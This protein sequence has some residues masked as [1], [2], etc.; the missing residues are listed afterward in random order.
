MRRVVDAHAVGAEDADAGA[1]ARL[2]L[3]LQQGR[4]SSAVSWNRPVKKWMTHPLA[5]AA[6]DQVEHR[7]GG[8]AGDDVFD[9]AGRW[10]ELG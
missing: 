2:Q 10:R 1:C 3:R 9:R 7:L 4:L 5:A 6:V 8:D